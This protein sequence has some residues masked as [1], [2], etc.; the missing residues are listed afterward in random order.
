MSGRIETNQFEYFQGQKKKLELADRR[1]VTKR[2]SELV[3]PGISGQ[4]V[5]ITDFTDVLATYDG[6]FSSAPGAIGAPDPTSAY[7]GH[8]VSDALIGGTQT[9]TSLTNNVIYQRTFLRNPADPAVIYWG[10]WNPFGQSAAGSI[11]IPTALG[12]NE[13]ANFIIN[14]PLRRFT[15]PPI[16]T[17]TAGGGGARISYE[18]QPPSVDSVS[19][20]AFNLT[21]FG[22]SA[23]TLY[24][25]AQHQG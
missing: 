19:G 2:A 20:V 3:G 12:P 5:R 7:I 24:W 14:F 10:S 6:F 9:F 13:S 16:V 8:V 17:L 4:A 22:A 11:S 25:N 21:A 23:F 1:P 15:Y 18:L